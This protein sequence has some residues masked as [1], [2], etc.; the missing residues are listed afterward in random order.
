MSDM[1]LVN[2]RLKLKISDYN[3][4]F[5]SKNGEINNFHVMR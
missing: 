4:T 1:S 5:D 3:E 2:L